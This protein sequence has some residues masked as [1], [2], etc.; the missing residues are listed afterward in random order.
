MNDG[1]NRALLIVFIVVAFPVVFTALWV[2]ITFVLSRVGGWH[3][4]ARRYAANGKPAGGKEIHYLTGMVGVVSYRLVLTVIVAEQGLYIATRKVFSVGHP[5][6]FIPYSAICNAQFRSLFFK[7][8]VSF[9]IEEEPIATV[10]LPSKV[11]DGVPV[12]IAR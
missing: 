8:Y 9:E 11:F 12:Q 3:R 7:E 6:L 10:W 5:P 1:T 2:S 4:V